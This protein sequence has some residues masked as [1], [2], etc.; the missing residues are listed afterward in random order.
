MPNASDTK[1]APT[2][3]I[4]LVGR[5]G[6]G[7]TAQIWSLPG[8]RFAYIFDPNS[9]QTLRGCDLDYEVFQPDFLELDAT[10]KG[11][12][13]GAKSDRLASRREPTVYLRWVEDINKK[14]EEGFFKTYDWLVIDSLTFLSKA[15][16]DRQL[17]INQRYGDIEELGDYRV[18]G[19]KISDLFSSIAAMPLNILATGHLQVFQDEKT[20]VLETSLQLPG[21][22]RNMLPLLFTNI[23]LATTSDTEKGVRYEVRTQPEQRGLRDIRTSLKNLAAVEDVTIPK[24]DTNAVEHG[25]GRL[26]K[27]R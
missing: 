9:L 2:Q 20:K 11:F 25:I 8:K 6:A 7:K 17:F 3:R 13:K 1:L 19:T 24:F 26:L 16:M 15:V 14:V 10:L 12:N 27:G 4:L 22:S 5:T 21:R 23:W 18:V